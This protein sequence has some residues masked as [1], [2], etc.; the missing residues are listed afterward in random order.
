MLLAYN[1]VDGLHIG[2]DISL[3]IT[4]TWFCLHILTLTF[5]NI[6]PNFWI[7]LLNWIILIRYDLARHIP[8]YNP[9]TAFFIA[10]LALIQ[11]A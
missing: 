9:N 2:L 1:C 8:S 11:G 7:I 10:D 5:Q 3:V 4:L 6:S